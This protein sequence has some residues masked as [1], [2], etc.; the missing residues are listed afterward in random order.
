MTIEPAA[1]APSGFDY[2]W[3][4]RSRSF[5]A[6]YGISPAVRAPW[7]GDGVDRVGRRC[8]VLAFGARNNALVEF[9]D[10]YRVVTC[11]RGLRRV[12]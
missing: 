1:P 9:E 2:V 10:G 3:T 8:R 7:F 4:W 6:A 12:A 11:R 5:G